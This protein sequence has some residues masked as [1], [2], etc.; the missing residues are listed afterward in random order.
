MSVR[1]ENMTQDEVDCF[2]KIHKNFLPKRKKRFETYEIHSNGK[3]KYINSTKTILQRAVDCLR[4][5]DITNFD[6]K[7]WCIDFHQR[8]CGFEKKKFQWYHWHQDDYAVIDCNVHTIIFYLRK[9]ISVSGG[10]FE[11]KK[12]NGEKIIQKVESKSILQFSGNLHHRPQEATG[13]GCRDSIVVFIKR[14]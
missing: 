6:E 4:T 13:F 10:D 8:N 1:C 12:D 7:K 3:R 2:T 9:D 14:T 5:N 11:Y